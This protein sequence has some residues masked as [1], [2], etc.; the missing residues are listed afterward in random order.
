M[1]C[2]AHEHAPHQ[3]HRRGTDCAVCGCR[4]WRGPVARR[5]P[6]PAPLLAWWLTRP[7]S[8]RLDLVA[9]ISTRRPVGRPS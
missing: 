3:H 2:C 4:A 7:L 1:R 5:V 8:A 6:V 9:T